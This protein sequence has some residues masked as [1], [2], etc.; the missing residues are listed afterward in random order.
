MPPPQE[1]A[2]GGAKPPKSKRQA[3]LTPDKFKYPPVNC[4]AGTNLGGVMRM[5]HP[6]CVP[7]NAK[8]PTPFET[9]LFKGHVQ[10]NIRG[11]TGTETD[12]WAEGERFH[13]KR[14]K[15]VFT[16]QG[17]FKERMRR[18]QVDCG[19]IWKSKLANLPWP[20]VLKA[21][22]GVIA[23]LC[24]GARSNVQAEVEPHF[25]N[26]LLA[27]ADTLHVRP[28]GG[29][30]MDTSRDIV[31][32]HGEFTSAKKRTQ[33]ARA[34]AKRPPAPPPVGVA[35]P[36]ADP[37][38]EDDDDADD[39]GQATPLSRSGSSS[40]AGGRDTAK[41]DPGLVDARFTDASRR[42]SATLPVAGAAED[43][44]FGWGFWEPENEY[45]FDFY[46]DKVDLARFAALVPSLPEIS[47]CRYFNGQPF[48]MVAR[49]L[50]GRIVWHFEVWHEHLFDRT[51]PNRLSLPDSLSHRSSPLTFPAVGDM[52][53]AS[54]AEGRHS[55]N[56]DSGGRTYSLLSCVTRATGHTFHSVDS[57]A[58]DD[59]QTPRMAPHDG[60]SS[61]QDFSGVPSSVPVSALA[62]SSQRGKKRRLLK[63]RTDRWAQWDEHLGSGNEP[64]PSDSLCAA[65]IALACCAFLGVV[66]YWWHDLVYQ[67]LRSS[68]THPPSA[69]GLLL[70][71]GVLASVVL[72]GFF[73]G[74]STEFVKYAE[75]APL[76]RQGIIQLAAAVALAVP[77]E[78]AFRALI[79]PYHSSLEDGREA[80]PRTTAMW[81]VLSVV[82]FVG[83]FPLMATTVF[84][85]G[86]PTFL[87]PRFL[88][89]TFIVGVGC[90]GAYLVSGSLWVAACV[91]AV[92]ALLWVYLG[93]GSR[94][95]RRVR[96]MLPTSTAEQR[97]SA[98][99]SFARRIDRS[100]RPYSPHYG[101]LDFEHVHTVPEPE[102]E[103]D[104]DEAEASTASLHTA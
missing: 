22:E 10:M 48:P 19:L 93:G 28:P 51:E 33:T 49:T 66:V 75:W 27:G 8:A 25:V 102:D 52:S 34:L 17:R 11:A 37:P 104:Y 69:F 61:L 101:T 103:H 76:N 100:P 31:F 57:V 82:L 73:V 9:D 96:I 53:E 98:G 74:S 97:P 67:R 16:V 20:F 91:N 95:L 62:G 21:A 47:L 60:R 32:E 54:F 18:D 30:P 79:I 46:G 3:F 39:G 59:L 87:D 83:H 88:A 99:G 92:S 42:L 94:R 41:G 84:P 45:T 64:R 1:M 63:L 40:S 4:R 36:P 70:S 15:L 55:R 13:G 77:E 38:E 2:E 65:C 89:L 78:M 12:P 81:T 7:I 26:N 44:S 56:S 80:D 58:A 6:E 29:D 5:E 71:A 23:S 86:Y 24:S 43:E 72:M 85:L 35:L 68:V 50:D 90:S 14:R